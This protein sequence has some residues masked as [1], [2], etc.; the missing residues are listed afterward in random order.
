MIELFKPKNEEK[1]VDVKRLRENLLLFI[2]E[3]LGRVE[4]GEGANIRGLHLFLTPGEHDRFLYEAAVYFEEE[5]R[6]QREEV[7]RIADDFAIELPAQWTM[8][9]SFVPQLPPEAIPVP[10]MSAGLFISTQ[11]RTIQNKATA[12][13]KV[14]NGEAEHDS[15]TLQ[16]SD[17]RLNIGRDKKVQGDDGFF[18]INQIAFPAASENNSNKF[19]SRQHAHIEFDNGSGHFLLF[20]DSGGIPPRNKI[21]VRSVNEATPVKLYS[22]RNAHVLEEGD[23]IMLGESAIL[24]FSYSQ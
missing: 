2:K 16:S 23:Q 7:Q 14:L 17:A 15:Y 13:L 1:T 24:E 10:Q 9:I 3:Q 20:A 8:E 18:R 22:V 4:G 12:Y 21:K 5:G 6:F 19:I 11:K